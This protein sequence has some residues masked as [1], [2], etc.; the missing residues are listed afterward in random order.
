MQTLAYALFATPIGHCG[1]AWSA[2]GLTGVQLPE[3]N[4]TATRARMARRFPQCQEGEPPASVREA[5]DAVVGLLSGSPP[6]HRRAGG[7]RSRRPGRAR[8]G[9]DRR[10][11]ARALQPG[12]TTTYGEM[13]RDLC[14]PGAARAVGQAL[15]SNPFAPIVPCHR[16]LAAHGRSGGFSAH[17]GADT[18]LR[19]LEIE[20]AQIDGPGL[21]D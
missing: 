18:K 5:M 7:R 13:A 4:A 19:L 10:A 20:R 3:G 8:C 1:I 17:G 14:E 6:Q 9:A 21:F 11:A 12:Q 16:I 2:A 15:G